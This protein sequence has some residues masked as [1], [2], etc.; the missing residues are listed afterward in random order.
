M[1]A[2]IWNKFVMEHGPRS[3]AFL[4]SWNWGEF[5]KSTG[6]EVKRY[7]TSDA[8]AQVISHPLP[9]GFYGWNLYRGPI[10]NEVRILNEIINDLKKSK[11][12]FLHLEPNTEFRISDFGFRISQN[13]QPGHTLI[14]NL[15]KAENELLA[16]MH[17]KTRY[18]IR[19]AERHGITVRQNAPVED[20][21]CLM[22]ETTARDRFSPHPESY[23]RD[24][25]QSLP[26]TK[27]FVAYDGGEP[28]A[29][30]IANFFGNTATY[31][32]G[33]SSNAKRNLMA[34][35]LLHWEIIKIAKARGC[36][37]YD[38]WGIAPPGATNH[39]WAGITRFKTG[40]GGE[41]VAMPAAL[42]LPLRPISYNIYKLVRR[43]RP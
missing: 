14:V 40:F 35:Y 7:E 4:Q 11:G 27:L 17:E 16:E 28:L 42:E 34:P 39:P 1:E 32:H 41:T 8:V 9:G 12:I 26:D 10:L 19:L 30:A 2:G 24:M 23:Y 33:A 31:L 36:L 15:Q 29:A 6:R 21:L 13:R 22:K 18:N 20:F 3:G 43:L 37:S 5:Q 25:L 38:F